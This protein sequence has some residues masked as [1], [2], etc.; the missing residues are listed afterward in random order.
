MK[1]RLVRDDGTVTDMAA[2]RRERRPVLEGRPEDTE[3]VL[4]LWTIAGLIERN[5]Q[6][7]VTAR[8]YGLIV[9]ECRAQ[10]GGSTTNNPPY[11]MLGKKPQLTVLN[12]GTDDQAAVNAMN[13]MMPGAI[14]FQAKKERL[15]TF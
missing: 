11:L 15:R 4:Q 2:W 14:D 7:Y 9:E 6:M 1:D 8:H 5:T 13:R 12:A 3:F 10:Y